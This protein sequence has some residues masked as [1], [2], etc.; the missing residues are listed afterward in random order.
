MSMYI[1]H[2]QILGNFYLNEIEHFAP[3]KSDGC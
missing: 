1:T 3:H 2:P